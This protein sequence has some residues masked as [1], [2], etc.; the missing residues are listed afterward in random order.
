MLDIDT[1]HESTNG[2]CVLEVKYAPGSTQVTRFMAGYQVGSQ[3]GKVVAPE[4][5]RRLSGF[6]KTSVV[7][8]RIR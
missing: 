2:Y 3:T 6:V 1:I 7:V 4:F 8:R 5:L